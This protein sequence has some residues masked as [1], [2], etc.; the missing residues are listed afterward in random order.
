M[1]LVLVTGANGFVG[2]ALCLCLSARGLDVRA[3]VR[4]SACGPMKGA[5]ETATVGEVDATTDWRK[6]LG[7]VEAIV[8]LAARAH[9]LDDRS[10]GPLTAFRAVNTEGTVRL[11][12]QAVEAGVKRFVFVSTVKVN[13]QAT[14]GRPFTADDQPAPQ[15]FYALSKWEAEQ[16][17]A[18]LT[19]EVDLE[20]AVLRP[21]LVYG[22]GVRA[23]F[24]ALMKAVQRGLP[25]PLGLVDNRRSLMGLDNLVS[26]LVECVTSPGAAGQTFLACDGE[27][28]STP[29]LIRR[30]AWLMGRPAR[31][32]PV[33]PALLRLAGWATGRLEQVDRLCGSLQA[34][35]SKAREVLTWTPPKSLDEGLADTVRWFQQAQAGAIT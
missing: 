15:D 30:L 3:A 27:D 29:N 22:P 10:P 21:P 2:R 35:G 12:Q 26:L 24:L 14:W 17:L 34:D 4:A 6:A 20:I 1:T 9:I 13:G 7:G 25:M 8:H 19:G 32:L 16:A 11:A 18:Q 23:N 5:A 31:L 28:V 33:P